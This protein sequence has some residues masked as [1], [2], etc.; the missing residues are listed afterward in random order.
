[1]ETIVDLRDSIVTKMLA[2]YMANLDLTSYIP[3][4]PLNTAECGIKA[5]KT[6]LKK[7]HRT[8]AMYTN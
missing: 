3:Y 7:S 2:L 6:P 5:N 1:M 8:F 4:G